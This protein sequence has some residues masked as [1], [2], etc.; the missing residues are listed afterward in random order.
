[1]DKDNLLPQSVAPVGGVKQ[2]RS[3]ILRFPL[4]CSVWG[5]LD[6]QMLGK[7]STKNVIVTPLFVCPKC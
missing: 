3:V 5:S 6:T 1:M 2:S 4:F 7:N